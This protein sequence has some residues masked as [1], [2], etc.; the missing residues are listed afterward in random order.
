MEAKKPL[1]TEVAVLFPRQ[2]EWTE[3]DFFALPSTNRK[4]ELANGRVS[5]APSPSNQHQAISMALSLAL[6][7]Y[8][9]EHGL[10]VVRYAPHDVRLY[11]GTV[12]QPDLFFV[13]EENRDR[14]TGQVFEGG[15]DW[16]AE[17]LSPA[18]RHADEVVKLAEYAQAGVPEYWL[19]G[20]EDTTIRIYT[21]A[22]E[23]YTLAAQVGDGEVAASTAIAGFEIAVDEVFASEPIT[24]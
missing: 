21:L 7:S 13:R 23:S 1:A 11:A 9:R 4:V 5:V 18:D 8:V 16:I 12:R 24:C 22:G 17:I 20:P 2:G 3:D 10:G 19:I 14:F 6:G 15:P